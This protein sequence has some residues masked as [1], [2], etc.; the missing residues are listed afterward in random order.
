MSPGLQS[1]FV[2]WCLILNSWWGMP[3][4]YNVPV[5]VWVTKLGSPKGYHRKLYACKDFSRCNTE[6]KVYYIVITY[7][8]FLMEMERLKPVALCSPSD[9]FIKSI[10]SQIKESLSYG[11]W[12]K[13]FQPT[14]VRLSK[15]AW[16]TPP[17]N[18]F[19]WLWAY[20]HNTLEV[21][22]TCIW[23]LFK[24]NE[25]RLCCPSGSTTMLDS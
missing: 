8:N 7:V 1:F 12:P 24:P 23:P 18:Y 14:S 15:S 4:D 3:S 20:G 2:S 9:S 25:R 16:H 6:G 5:L 10:C 11:K 21:T 22:V 17:L 13:I 19:H